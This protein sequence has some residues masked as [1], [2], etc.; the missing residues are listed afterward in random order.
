MTR[1][2]SEQLSKW[3]WRED[4]GWG[5]ELCQ[6]GHE[7]LNTTNLAS[8]EGR[9]CLP[10]RRALRRRGRT[11]G[12][13]W[14]GSS[15]TSC[16]SP[17]QSSSDSRSPVAVVPAAGSGRSR[18]HSD[19]DAPAIRSK[20]TKKGKKVK[21][22]FIQRSIQSVG[23]LKALYTFCLPWQTCSFRHQRSFSGKHSSQ[24]AITRQD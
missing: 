23:S 21:V 19:G 1:K 10:P 20:K 16:V 9:G 17:R 7:S 8:P 6:K 2:T 3:R 24:A 18:R 12:S 22:V 15:G 13:G 4:L 14:R 11:L 5:H